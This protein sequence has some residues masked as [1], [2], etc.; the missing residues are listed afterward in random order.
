MFILNHRENLAET[1]F[2]SFIVYFLG[3]GGGHFDEIHQPARAPT[4]LVP[5]S[6]LTYVPFRFSTL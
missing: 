4:H 5:D 6:P 2:F 3:E 1:T